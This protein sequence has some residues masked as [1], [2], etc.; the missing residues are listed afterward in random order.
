MILGIA[1]ATQSGTGNRT[2]GDCSPIIV[3]AQSV[4]VKGCGLDTEAARRLQESINQTIGQNKL[5]IAQIEVLA[6]TLNGLLAQTNAIDQKLDWIISNL[7]GRSETTTASG[8]ARS[9]SVLIRDVLDRTVQRI[10]NIKITLTRIE[11]GNSRISIYFDLVNEG[12]VEYKKINIFGGGSF[13]N[14]GSSII[15]GGQEVLA[16]GVQFAG[17]ASRGLIRSDLIPRIRYTGR[18]DFDGVYSDVNAIDA[19]KLAL[20]E[21]NLRPSARATFVLSN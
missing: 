21:N 7:E 10:D 15:L 17:G 19:F 1:L 8:S 2:S 3:S 5:T 6:A 14:G 16:T 12:V 9:E 4:T 20:S 11:S 18:V 13:G